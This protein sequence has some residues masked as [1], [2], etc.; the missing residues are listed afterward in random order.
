MTVL[1]KW[2]PPVIW[3][4]LIFGG[5]TDVLSGEHTSRFVEP[6]LRWL[7]FGMLTPEQVAFG[8]LLIRKAGHLTE[9]AVVSVLFWFA[10]GRPRLEPDAEPHNRAPWV[11]VCLALA[12]SVV[13]AALAEYPQSFVPSRPS[14][15]HDVAI[16]A[17]GAILG[18][19]LLGAAKLGRGPWEK[20]TARPQSETFA[21]KSTENTKSGRESDNARS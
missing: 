10:L 4:A 20:R 19:S 8:H 7:S 5:S 14:S 13:Y 12:L 15:W 2:L 16:D 1:R 11:A 21:T 9:Y 17:G 3:M 6:L 18:L